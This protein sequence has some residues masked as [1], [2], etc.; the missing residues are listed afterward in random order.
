VSAN[1]ATTPT[2]SAAIGSF[3]IDTAQVDQAVKPGDDFFNYV[4]GKWL[5]SFQIPADKSRY[6]IFDALRDTAEEDV[7]AIVTEVAA[8]SSAEGSTEQ[9]VGDLYAGWMDVA[10]IAARGLDPLQPRL[11][12]IAALQNTDQLQRLFGKIDYAAPF[13]ISILPDPKDTTRYTI[14]IDQAGLGMP[15]RDYYLNE[16]ERFNAYRAA[17]QEYVTTVF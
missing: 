14:S 15:D 5:D 8:A 17:Y 4:N 2:A 1:V 12:E 6:G 3:G 7:H 10:T 16:G 11:D 13:S 9:T